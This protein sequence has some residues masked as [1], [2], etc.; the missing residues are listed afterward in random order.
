MKLQIILALMNITVGLINGWGGNS[1]IALCNL[2]VATILIEVIN[3]QRN[4]KFW[5]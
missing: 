1:L 5:H 2:V 4:G 3:Y